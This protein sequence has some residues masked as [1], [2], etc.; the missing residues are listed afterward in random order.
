MK[1]FLWDLIFLEENR[2][3]VLQPRHLYSCIFT[4]K[5][6]R[7]RIYPLKLWFRLDLWN[8]CSTYSYCVAMLGLES[9]IH[10]HSSSCRK[11]K[12]SF[13]D[14]NELFHFKAIFEIICYLSSGI[15]TSEATLLTNEISNELWQLGKNGSYGEKSW[16]SC[17]PIVQWTCS[18]CKIWHTPLS[19]SISSHINLFEGTDGI[20]FTNEFPVVSS[21]PS[22]CYVLKNIVIKGTHER[23]FICNLMST[24]WAVPCYMYDM[25]DG[26]PC[27]ESSL[28]SRSL[29]FYYQ[30]VKLTYIAN[31]TV[32]T[33]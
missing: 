12:G 14:A 22:T 16:C 26:P 18:Y 20:S 31:Q 28:S 21:L 6:C 10:S 15:V 24:G 32:D 23:L 5:I 17:P 8:D 33:I 1:I 2:A 9:G 25:Y 3:G 7:E 11:E 30:S 19:P 27:Q 13:N 29:D 4:K